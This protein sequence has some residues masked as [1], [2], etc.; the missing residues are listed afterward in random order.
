[1]NPPRYIYIPIRFTRHIEQLKAACMA[2]FGVEFTD[3]QIIAMVLHLFFKRGIPQI[4]FVPKEIAPK[5][6]LHGKFLSIKC[7]ENKQKLVA[8]AAEVHETSPASVIVTAIVSVSKLFFLSSHV[9]ILHVP[10]TKT[11]IPQESE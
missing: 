3:D 8:A 7:P 1:M 6:Y 9:D 5:K 4:N 2:K 11:A 10:S